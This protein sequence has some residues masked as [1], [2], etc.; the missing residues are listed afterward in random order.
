MSK[1]DPRVTLRQ[2]A[3]F[4]SEARSLVAT[5][6]L[7]ELQSDPVRLRAFERVMELVGESAKRLPDEL[8]SSY[9]QVPWRQV[10]GMR[11]VISHAYEDLAYEILWDAL[12]LHFPQLQEAVSQMLVDLD[13]AN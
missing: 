11:D 8:R 1:H 10:A 5:I 7:E 6:S 4:I 9:P 3:E 12:H 13:S 2:L